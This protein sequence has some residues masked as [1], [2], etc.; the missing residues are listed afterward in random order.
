M[1]VP[2]SAPGMAESTGPLRPICDYRT[3][4]DEPQRG[5]PTPLPAIRNDEGKQ[6]AVLLETA[7][8][9]V[10]EEFQR[11][12]RLDAKARHQLTVV[13]ALFAVVMATTAG[14]LNALLS[15]G[16]GSHRGVLGVL[17][18][19]SV[20]ATVAPW[21]YPTLGAF[22][23]ASIVCL[24]F[25]LLASARVWRTREQDALDPA[26]IKEYVA[27]AERA[28]LGVSKRL[29]EAYADILADRREK[30]KQRKDHLRTASFL[31][32]LAG[33]ASL[34]LLA[35]VFIALITQ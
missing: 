34:A 27:Y 5:V 28:N 13:G 33:V 16:A 30:N 23:L 8:A 17:L 7:R 32:V 31:A 12:E 24:L 29:I 25:A 10:A 3:V 18:D 9:L 22:A 6:L 11:S 21:V 1:R 15:V 26:T 19:G 20:T 14:V 4:S 2:H 35:A